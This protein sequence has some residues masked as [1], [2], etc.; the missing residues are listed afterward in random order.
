[1]P[2]F[3]NSVFATL[4][5]KEDN[6]IGVDKLVQDSVCFELG[7]VC[8]IGD[9]LLR[10]RNIELVLYLNLVVA[11]QFKYVVSVV[12]EEIQLKCH[13]LYH[14]IRFIIIIIAPQRCFLWI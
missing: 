14:L 9:F 1:M 13:V 6:K 7:E 8:H 5:V 4:S 12:C 3:G 10:Q 2:P 11:Q